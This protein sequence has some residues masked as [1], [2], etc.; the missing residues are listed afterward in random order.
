M[1]DNKNFQY[2]KL[3]KKQSK[4][5]YIGVFLNQEKISK[6][7]VVFRIFVFHILSIIS[8][9]IKVIAEFWE[10]GDIPTMKSWKWVHP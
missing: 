4:W 6:S 1:W 5:S 2:V 8:F 7:C 3:H 10:H 9:I